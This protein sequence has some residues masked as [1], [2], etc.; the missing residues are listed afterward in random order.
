MQG[1][2]NISPE[3]RFRKGLSDLL[4]GHLAWFQRSHLV[5]NNIFHLAEYHRGICSG[6][7]DRESFYVELSIE[8]GHWWPWQLS[9]I[10]LAPH[11]HVGE[12]ASSGP[13]LICPSVQTPYGQ[14]MLLD[15]SSRS[16]ETCLAIHLCLQAC[17]QQTQ[18][19][20]PSF[21]RSTSTNC[22]TSRWAKVAVLLHHD[23]KLALPTWSFQPLMSSQTCK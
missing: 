10:F 2:S 21:W 20:L 17:A 3:L 1:V 12:Q 11:R 22:W 8:A 19:G 14:E 23:T 13:V 15:T 4:Q 9:L 18:V 16:L 6:N 5:Q 7:C